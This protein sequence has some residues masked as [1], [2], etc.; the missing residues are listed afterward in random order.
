MHA[1]MSL[2]CLG[3]WMHECTHACH[4]FFISECTHACHIF[5]LEGHGHE[6]THTCHI[7]LDNYTLFIAVLPLSPPVLFL[8]LVA[9]Q[10]AGA[11]ENPRICSWRATHR[12]TQSHSD[13][14][15]HRHAHRHG[16]TDTSRHTRTDTRTWRHTR[17]KTHR[18]TRTHF[19]QILR[20]FSVASRFRAAPF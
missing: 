19:R 18:H 2:F 4:W 6:R 13:T 17:T 1:R 11:T 3:S 9:S 5:S 20:G 12:H 7:C 8:P 14:L 10:R 15:L 16:C